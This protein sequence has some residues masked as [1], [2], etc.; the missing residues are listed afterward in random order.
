MTVEQGP[1]PWLVAEVI[2]PFFDGVFPLKGKVA[3]QKEWY[4]KARQSKDGIKE[5]ARD[6]SGYNYAVYLKSLF[7]LDCDVEGPDELKRELAKL[8]ELLGQFKPAFAVVTGKHRYHIYCDAKGREIHSQKLTDC[9]HIKGWHGYVV[10]PGSWHPETKKQYHICDKEGHNDPRKL[11]ELSDET[12]D[13]LATK[14][15]AYEANGSGKKNAVTF[16]LGKGSDVLDLAHPSCIR[17]LMLHG[18]PADQ[19][20]V[21][22]NHTI[23]RY[24]L[25]AGLTDGDGAAIASKMAVNTSPVHPTGKDTHDKVYNFSSCMSSARNNPEH[26]QFE[27][28][29]VRGSE[30][31]IAGNIC[32]GCSQEGGTHE[33]IPTD[34]KTIIRARAVYELQH[35]DPFQYC[36]DTYQQSHAS[37]VELG[38]VTLLSIVNQSVLNSIGIFPKATGGSGKGK[39]SGKTAVVHLV[40]PKYVFKRSFS[41]KALFYLDLPPE[42]ILFFDDRNLS[43]GME[44]LVRCVMDDFQGTKQHTSV[45]EGKS[46]TMNIP[47]RCMVMFTNV[48]SSLNIQ[49]AN[50][51]VDVTVDESEAADQAVHNI[52]VKRAEA[53]APKYPETFEVMVCREIFR[54]IKEEIGPFRVVV[55][56]ARFIN[57]PGKSNR[58]NFDIFVDFI[59][60]F[61]AFRC[62]Q[63]KTREGVIFADV[64]DFDD[65][66][67]LYRSLS[68]T[69]T[70]KLTEREWLVVQAI[71]DNDKSATMKELVEALK[72]HHLSYYTIRD[73]VKG[74]KNKSS[75]LLDKVDGLT[76][77][78]VRENWQDANDD[79]HSRSTNEDVFTLPDDFE[80]LAMYDQGGV[81]TLSKGAENVDLNELELWK[82]L[83]SLTSVNGSL[84]DVCQSAKYSKLAPVEE[85]D[86][87]IEGYKQQLQ[88]KTVAFAKN[89][90]CVSNVSPPPQRL[91]QTDGDGGDNDLTLENRVKA[92][93]QRVSGQNGDEKEAEIQ[94]NDDID[95]NVL[96]THL[97]KTVSKQSLA[98]KVV[99]NL[100]TDFDAS[101]GLG[102][103]EGFS[104][105]KPLDTPHPHTD[106]EFL[107][108]FEHELMLFKHCGEREKNSKRF[109]SDDDVYLEINKRVSDARHLHLDDVVQAGN[110]LRDHPTIVRELDNIFNRAP[111]GKADGSKLME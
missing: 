30:E 78:S 17:K 72:P 12:L 18:A 98:I 95:D 51:T 82:P 47:P 48:D 107:W 5:Y 63:R 104:G 44:E 36:F 100:H 8:V 102:Y 92:S 22:A 27:C 2:G 83:T 11:T 109:V 89:S 65:A 53:G 21:Q 88:Q 4:R 66:V 39:T 87:V 32:S 105:G 61:A 16:D 29:Y 67:V 38:K 80:I 49:T 111:R 106:D 75:G 34:I 7:V 62:M 57:W 56:Y 81:I 41:D 50:R 58:R 31:L 84:K 103:I 76:V 37:D 13:R 101:T 110:R 9:T 54:I 33:D 40:P 20:Y 96:C 46:Q 90:E 1:N 3:F 19:D 91:P 85:L 99:D 42:A 60:G 71:F 52:S 68:K 64:R 108:F 93:K 97:V 24:V 69:Q 94:N 73:I 43:E 74:R 70:S 77:T 28:S 25:S 15:I 14:R 6:W 59:H 79:T 55:P 35:R 45:H 10:G 86:S 23:A 26:N